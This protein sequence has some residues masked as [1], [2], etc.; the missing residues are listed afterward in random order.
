MKHSV[1]LNRGVC[2]RCDLT[3]KVTVNWSSAVHT[4]HFRLQHFTLA[5]FNI[6]VFPIMP[7]YCIVPAF[8]V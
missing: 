7:F 4:V 8:D 5:L 3:S 1:I 2:W 6:R